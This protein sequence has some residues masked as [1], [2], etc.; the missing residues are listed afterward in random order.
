VKEERY[1]LDKKAL[2]DLLSD[3]LHL[4][5]LHYA[6]WFNEMEHQ[7]G[8]D[9][10]IAV[11]ELVWPQALSTIVDRVAKRLKIPLEEDGTAKILAD[12]SK[13]TSSIF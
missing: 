4:I 1:S 13:G 11:D 12:A 9:K 5:V 6:I 7:L 2:I 8:L 3:S 10:A